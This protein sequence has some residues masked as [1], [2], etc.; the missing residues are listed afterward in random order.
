MSARARTATSLLAA[1]AIVAIAAL[2]VIGASGGSAKA[3]CGGATDRTYLATAFAVARQINTGEHVGHGAGVAL[4]T[5]EGDQTLIAAVAADD[6]A[7]VRTEVH[8]LVYNH[9]HIVRLRVLR[10]GLVLDDLGGPLVLAPVTGSLRLGG[11]VVGTFVMSVQ[12]EAG[13]RKLVERLVGGRSVIRYQGRTV[14]SDIGLRGVNLPAAGSVRIGGVRYLVKRFS[15][16]R[17]PSGTLDIWLL[18]RAPPPALARA[19]CGQ[20][21]AGVLAGVAERAYLES[22]NGPPVRPALKTLALDPALPPA[23]AARDFAG[24]ARIVAGIVA[25]GG[26]ARL[27]VSAGGRLVADVGTRKPLLAPLRRTIRDASGAVVGSALFAVQSAAGYAILAS[28][29]TGAAV[30]VRAGARQL[31]GSFAG[32]RK[33]PVSGPLTYR[34][35]RYSVAS[36]A[37]AAFPGL[38]VRI[39]VLDPLSRPARA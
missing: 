14:M 23:L 1:A 17:F 38:G 7:A 13:Y 33:V 39:Y 32:P 9:E 25:G 21:A 12:D 22:L 2:L 11:R 3:A 18:F 10:A 15:D 35:V 20:V 29:L 16:G 4:S 8:A 19:A 28:A 27:R 37:A 36:F 24:A 31:A 6:V 34:G 5:I 30:L 26:F